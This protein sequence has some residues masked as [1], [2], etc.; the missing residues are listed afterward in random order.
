[1]SLETQ[2]YKILRTCTC[3]DVYRQ[4]SEHPAPCAGGP[5]GSRHR[6]GYRSPR[7]VQTLTLKIDANIQP[8]PEVW[9]QLSAKF[10]I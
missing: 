9:G 5:R 3:E 6:S 10:S 8:K 2:K 4:R 7:T 1:M